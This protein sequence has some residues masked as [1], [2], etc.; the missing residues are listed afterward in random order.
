MSAPCS[1]PR[2]AWSERRAGLGGAALPAVKANLLGRLTQAI[3]S[4]GLPAA[5]QAQA[6]MQV[7]VALDGWTI[8]L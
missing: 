8:K 6:M 2:R 7:Q 1:K 4:A 5:Y 3:S